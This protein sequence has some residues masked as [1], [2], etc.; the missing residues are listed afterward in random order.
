MPAPPGP[1]RRGGQPWRECG[2]NHETRRSSPAE[3]LP[4]RLKAMQNEEVACPLI[5][6][7][8]K[9]GELYVPHPN[10]RLAALRA[11]GRPPRGGG[12]GEERRKN[13]ATSNALSPPGAVGIRGRHRGDPP[14][15]P[16]DTG[17]ADAGTETWCFNPL[18][19]ADQKPTWKNLD[20]G[21]RVVI[22]GVFS[23]PFENPGSGRD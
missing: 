18:W 15:L 5:R 12:D 22:A 13:S 2:N 17:S 20:A 21:F 8:R 1:R 7:S 4:L 9:P 3:G 14:G 16:G 11:E 6:S 23:A 19:L 10:I